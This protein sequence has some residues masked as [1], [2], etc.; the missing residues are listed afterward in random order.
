MVIE[1]SKIQNVSYSSQKE[2]INLFLTTKEIQ[3]IDGKRTQVRSELRICT[4][5]TMEY[6]SSQKLTFQN[7]VMLLIE[8]FERLFHD[9][10]SE[11]LFIV[12]AKFISRRFLDGKQ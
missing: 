6:A 1:N 7:E 10:R 2:V 5:Q 8:I 4:F 12:L 3:T 9:F 11:L